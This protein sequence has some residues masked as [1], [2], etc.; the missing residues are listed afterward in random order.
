MDPKKENSGRLLEEE[1]AELYGLTPEEEKEEEE[2]C[3]GSDS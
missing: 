2:E 3:S 1:L